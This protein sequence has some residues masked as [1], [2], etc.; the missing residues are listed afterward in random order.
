MRSFVG[1]LSCYLVILTCVVS[2]HLVE[3][4]EDDLTVSVTSD[5]P[6][7]SR[8]TNDATHANQKHTPLVF[9]HGLGDSCCNPLSLG[10]F[11]DFVKEQIPGVYINSLKIGDTMIQEVEDSYFMN[12]ND[13]VRVAC[14]IIRNDSALSGGYHAL[15]FSQGSQFLRAV[16]QRCPD[17]PMINLVSLGGQ[18]QG[19][20]GFPN[21]PGDNSTLCEYVRRL[22]NIGAYCEDVQNHLVPA[23]YWHDPFH[24]ETY[25]AKSIFLADINNERY[26]NETYKQN[27]LKLKNFVLV[28]YEED[29]VVDPRN[30]SW[31][32]YYPD[33]GDKT[34]V[35]LQ[36]QKIY[37]E[38]WIGLKQLDESG[39]LVFLSTPGD[40]LQTDKQWFIDNIIKYLK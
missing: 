10:G 37:T 24:R 31:F 5:S 22:L 1:F 8:I 23:Q 12:T 27:L 28:V 9:W 34:I 3:T 17:P 33:N 20:F 39:R 18:H 40:H 38:D 13:Q 4:T 26:K 32:G 6:R 25:A 14:E 19:V 21:C 2:S 7:D 29:S 36:Q 11:T 35:P 16:A 15:G 30:S